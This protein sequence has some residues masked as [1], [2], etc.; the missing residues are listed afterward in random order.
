M[1]LFRFVHAADIHLDSPFAA[2]GAESE[3]LAQKFIESTRDAFRRVVDLC[4]RRQADFLVLAGDVYDGSHKS[5]RAQLELRSG[6][7]ALA[8]RGIHTFISCGNHDHLGGWRASLT[9][10]P[11]VHF[12]GPEVEVHRVVRDGEEVARVQGVSYPRAAVTE[13]LA[14]GFRKDPAGPFAVG[15]LHAN[16]GGVPSHENYS[17]CTLEDLASTGIDYWALGHVHAPKTLR[18]HGP[19]VVYPGSTQGRNPRET[20]PHGC[21]VVT[22]DNG[23]VS[24]IEFCPVDSIRWETVEVSIDELE[25]LDD[26]VTRAEAEIIRAA[27][28]ADGRSLVVRV[29][30]GGRGRLDGEVRRSHVSRDILTLI[31][32]RLGGGDPFIWVESL[33]SNTTKEVDIEAFRREGSLV[34]DFLSEVEETLADPEALDMLRRDL[35]QRLRRRKLAAIIESMEAE[36]FKDVVRAAGRL[37]L[38]LLLPEEV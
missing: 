6:L 19:T 8:R 29:I 23:A 16:V 31:R 13:N 37:G 9:W 15:V 34:S 36:E 21:Q 7:G 11:E 26:L 22:V 2:V 25:T 30:L 4:I 3:E 17:P 18:D 24:S 1:T 33:I 14:A 20:G 12:F 27:A 38:D 10:P 5:L 32:D 35:A 28:M